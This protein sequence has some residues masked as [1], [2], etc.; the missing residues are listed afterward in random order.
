[1]LKLNKKLTTIQQVINRLNKHFKSTLLNVKIM[2]ARK[3]NLLNQTLQEF[4]KAY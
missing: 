4:L 1:M 3:L 2:I